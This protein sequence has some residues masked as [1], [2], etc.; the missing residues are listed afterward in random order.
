MKKEKIGNCC[1][2]SGQLMVCDPCYIEQEWGE[3]E[4]STFNYQGA[5]D[6]TLP[7]KSHGSMK[8]RMGHEGAGVAFATYGD[9]TYPVYAERGANG[10]IKRV[11]IKLH[12]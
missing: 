11:I 10:L 9:G 4:K 3:E 6:V 8:F 5:S 2:D 7:K 12:E 1:V